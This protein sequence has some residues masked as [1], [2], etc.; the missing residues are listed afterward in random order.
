MRCA[1]TLSRQRQVKAILTALSLPASMKHDI[2]IRL[3]QIERLADGLVEGEF[4]DLGVSD[5]RVKEEI[6]GLLSFNVQ[7]QL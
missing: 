4:K 2:S 3:L 7:D 6:A 1:R 5:K